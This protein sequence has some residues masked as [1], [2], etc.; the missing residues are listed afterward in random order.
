MTDLDVTPDMFL[1]ALPAD[2]TPAH[3]DQFDRMAKWLDL[4]VQTEKVA[5][6]LARTSFIPEPLRGQPENIAAAMMKALELGIDP[7]DGLANMHVIKGKVGFSAE[8]M[9]R[10]ILQA[11]H[12]IVID[13]STDERCRIRGRRNGSTEWQQVTFTGDQARKAKIDLGAYPADKL[14]ARASSRLCRRMFPDVL[15]GM[16]LDV[17]LED[18]PA[19]TSAPPK[20]GVQRKRQ[21]RKPVPVSHVKPAEPR[22]PDDEIAELLGDE[23]EPDEVD[24]EQAVAN[25]TAAGLVTD[26]SD[27]TGELL[28]DEPEPEPVTAQQLKLLAI[29]FRDHG[30]DDRQ[31]R[32]DFC[33]QIIGRALTSSKELTKAEASDVLDQLES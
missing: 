18:A 9:R 11:G 2:T 8:F 23:P 24:E 5:H 4:F 33:A 31:A 14:V 29:R 6:I 15:A 27:E 13:E 10:R 19:T 17:D 28:I 7:L 16:P 25:I 20:A 22:P 26:E 12:E 1:P 32:I 30:L 21:P 3:G